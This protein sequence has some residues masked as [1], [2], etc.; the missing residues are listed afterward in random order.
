[1]GLDTSHDC[2]HGPYTSFGR[3]REELA[4]TVGVDLDAMDGFGGVVSWDSLK[5]DILH[6]LLH[7]SDCGG[8]LRAEICGPL[9]DRM[10]ELLPLM[11]DEDNPHR[12]YTSRAK[13]QRFI[14]GLRRASAAGEN[15]DFH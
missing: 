7:H 1:M 9:A 10:E 8:E 12:D 6:E 4:K 3:W 14:D 13:T 2:W 11:S 15:V 5:P